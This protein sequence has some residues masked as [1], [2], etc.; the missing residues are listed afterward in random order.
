L[1][2]TADPIDPKIINQFA[3]GVQLHG[4]K[5]LTRPAHLELLDLRSARLT[6]HEGKYHQVKRMFAATGNRVTQL[7]RE[8]I[9]AVI[10]D[11]MLAPGEYRPLTENE[12]LEVAL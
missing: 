7:H 4:E 3:E 2:T 8:C 1:V 5:Y 12:I 10:L 9:G 6:I 11:S